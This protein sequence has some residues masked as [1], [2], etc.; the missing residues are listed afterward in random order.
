M[1]QKISARSQCCV[2]NGSSHFSPFSQQGLHQHQ[3]Q[4]PENYWF[5][6]LRNMPSITLK[7]LQRSIKSSLNQYPSFCWAPAMGAT[8]QP[9]PN[10]TSNITQLDQH[11]GMKFRSSF[12]RD[13][14]CTSQKI[15]PG[16]RWP[17]MLCAILSLHHDALWELFL[18][19]A[20]HRER[21]V[22]LY[23][24]LHG[25][26]SIE[27][28]ASPDN[29]S[30]WGKLFLKA[31]STSGTTRYCSWHTKKVCSTKWAF[32]FIHRPDRTPHG[33]NSLYLNACALFRFS[34]TRSVLVSSCLPIQD[35]MTAFV[36]EL[37]C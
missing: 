6:L 9:C 24:E 4:V 30:F 10:Q 35:D 21:C 11:V 2:R 29:G 8:S 12:L 27:E 28:Q 18:W 20:A 13:I 31:A 14:H 3:S 16:T 34:G 1:N 22:P 5:P 33:T 17:L 15:S 26:C 37:Q 7:N 36:C 32:S 25:V 19:H 23:R